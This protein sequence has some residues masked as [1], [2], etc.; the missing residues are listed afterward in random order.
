[1]RKEGHAANGQEW[2]RSLGWAA[3]DCQFLDRDSDDVR[4]I[5]HAH[6]SSG[7]EG[8]FVYAFSGHLSTYSTLPLPGGGHSLGPGDSL[9]L[10]PNFLAF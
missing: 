8:G 4:E 1:M 6:R 7:M 2:S 3:R 5:S 9:S 10:A